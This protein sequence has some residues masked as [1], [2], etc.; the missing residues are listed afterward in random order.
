LPALGHYPPT[1][2]TFDGEMVSGPYALVTSRIGAGRRGESSLEY[3]LLE[4]GGRWA[5][6]DVAV[7]GVSLVQSYRS[8]FNSILRSARFSELLDRLRSRE[9]NSTT[10]D[11]EGR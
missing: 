8:Q 2:V 11:D 3:R 10:R 6:Y 1:T 9:A 7:N 5:V 4:T